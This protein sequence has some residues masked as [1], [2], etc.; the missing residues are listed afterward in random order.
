MDRS[1]KAALL[2][3]LVFPGV[4]QMYLGRALRGGLLALAAAAPL[5]FV[6]A[7]ALRIAREL[8]AGVESRAI[9][10]DLLTLLQMAMDAAHRASQSMNTAMLV[11]LVLW[12]IAI[13]DAHRLGRRDAPGEDRATRNVS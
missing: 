1:G 11:F 4:G 13:V 3:A 5:Y 6:I 8:V 10:P 2:S 7:T 9:P 12:V